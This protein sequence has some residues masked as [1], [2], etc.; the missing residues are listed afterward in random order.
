MPPQP[1]LFCIF[2]EYKTKAEK[3]QRS[4]ANT[5]THANDQS[6]QDEAESCTVLFEQRECSEVRSTSR[7]TV[8]RP[9]HTSPTIDQPDVRHKLTSS[10]GHSLR[11]QGSHPPSHSHIRPT[12][13][14]TCGLFRHRRT[15]ACLKQIK[16]EISP[17]SGVNSFHRSPSQLTRRGLQQ[18]PKISCNGPLHFVPTGWD[19][20]FL[21][22]LISSQLQLL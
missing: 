11:L 10:V 20:L 9:A 19:F 18:N 6:A 14:L 15:T 13:E 7:Q 22:T 8:V 5:P 21:Q 3:L 12:D 2:H 17:L 1:R 4:P 16:V